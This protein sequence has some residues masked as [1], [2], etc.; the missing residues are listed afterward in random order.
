MKLTI[1]FTLVLLATT[2][3][4]GCNGKSFTLQSYADGYFNDKNT[5]SKESP[6]TVTIKDETVDHVKTSS[7]LDDKTTNPALKEGPGADIAWSSTYKQDKKTEGKGAL[8]QSLD[9]WTDEEWEPAFVGDVNQSEQDKAAHEH[10]TIQHYVDKAGKYLDKK[11]EEN[12]GKPKEPAHYEKMESL[13][14]IG[15]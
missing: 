8:Q 15:K 12:A 14:V 11:E 4:S 6:Q 9:T 1:Q 7:S 5:S 10:F 2:L 3:L 13:P